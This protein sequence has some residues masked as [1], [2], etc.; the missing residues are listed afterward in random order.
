MQIEL[1]F[2]IKIDGD[3]TAYEYKIEDGKDEHMCMLVQEA[4]KRLN[5]KME[6]IINEECK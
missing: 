4:R 2:S 1:E 6:K 5:L 3:Q